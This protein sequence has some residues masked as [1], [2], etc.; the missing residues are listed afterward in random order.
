M[1][2]LQAQVGSASRQLGGPGPRMVEL[3]PGVKLPCSVL[4]FDRNEEVFVE[5]EDADFVYKVISGAVRDVSIL[6]DGR[7]Q[8]GAF[9][10]P[11][12][13]FGLECGETHLYSAEAVM[14]SEIALVRRSSL[15]R[16]LEADAAGA[17]KV[18]AITARAL[19][20]LQEHM[21]LLARKSAV[22]RVVSFLLGMSE[23]GGSPGGIDLPMPR[24]DI[25]DFLGLTVETI[26]RTLSQLERDHA[27]SMPSS[28]RIL[29]HGR[30]A[31][32]G[33]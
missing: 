3:V 27:I 22:E 18:W 16:A 25:A 9:H 29:L 8:V 20:R 19:Q 24:G 13:V 30:L 1:Q 7:R 5:E 28:R 2:T 10:L 12:D 17:R 6:S 11:G 33:M 4:R 23:R 32:A 26:S 21:V 15:E 31:F 14:A